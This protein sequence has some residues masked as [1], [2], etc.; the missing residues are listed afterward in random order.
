MR[1]VSGKSQEPESTLLTLSYKESKPAV[2]PAPI[3][4]ATIA[5]A[6]VVLSGQSPVS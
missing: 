4:L 1:S 2:D 5:S 6:N 3:A